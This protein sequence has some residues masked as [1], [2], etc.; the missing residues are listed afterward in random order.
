[1]R[2]GAVYGDPMAASVGRRRDHRVAGTL[3]VRQRLRFIRLC[4]GL[5]FARGRRTVA[6]WLRACAG[7]AGLPTP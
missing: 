5:L 7:G 3:D 2:R 1:M 4:G 6:S